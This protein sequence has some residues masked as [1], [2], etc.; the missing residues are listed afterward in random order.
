M[1]QIIEIPTKRIEHNIGEI[2]LI[3]ANPKNIVGRVIIGRREEGSKKQPQYLP[4][5]VNVTQILENET[6][7]G[8]LTEADIVSFGKCLK[9][10]YSDALGIDIKETEDII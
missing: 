4:T 2:N 10:L 7:E 1:P 5:S 6:K 3:L 9:A 8:N